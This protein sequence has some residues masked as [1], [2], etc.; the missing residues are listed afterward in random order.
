MSNYANFIWFNCMAFTLPQALILWKWVLVAQLCPTLCDSMDCS[1]PGSSAYGILQARIL[2]CGSLHQGKFPTQGSNP[3][4][5][6]CRWILYHLSHQVPT[7]QELS[8]PFTENR[9]KHSVFKCFSNKWT[10]NKNILSTYYVPGTVTSLLKIFIYLAALV[11]SCSMWDLVS[12]P[13]IKPEPPELR[14]ES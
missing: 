4:L 12:W 6:H 7:R 5:L 14:T 10:I 3:G 8:P 11:L 1:P 13:T 2:D 9:P